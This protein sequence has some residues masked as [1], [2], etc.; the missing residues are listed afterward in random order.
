MI[1][2]RPLVTDKHFFSETL[3]KKFKV[4]RFTPHFVTR[5]LNFPEDY[6]MKLRR[7]SYR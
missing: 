7:V 4:L 2:R 3:M 1:E 6:Y 5:F